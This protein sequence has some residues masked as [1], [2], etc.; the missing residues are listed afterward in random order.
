M[1]TT[2]RKYNYEHGSNM[3][4]SEA[5]VESFSQTGGYNVIPYFEGWHIHAS[6]VLEYKIYD[7]DLPMLYYLRNLYTND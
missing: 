7:Q 1:H 2:F 4:S 3:S 5:I 6:E